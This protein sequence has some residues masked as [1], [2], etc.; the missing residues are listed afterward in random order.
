MYEPVLVFLETAAKVLDFIL[1][2]NQSVWSA[3][4]CHWG[5]V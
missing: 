2:L 4:K 5:M 3:S 1:E